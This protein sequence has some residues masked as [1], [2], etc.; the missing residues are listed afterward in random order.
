MESLSNNY[1]ECNDWY[2]PAR[3]IIIKLLGYDAYSLVCEAFD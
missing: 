2:V 3:Y 1:A